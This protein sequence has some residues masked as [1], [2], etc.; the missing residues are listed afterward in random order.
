MLSVCSNVIVTKL[1]LFA[2]KLSASAPDDMLKVF[3]IL[4]RK[5]KR[6]VGGQKQTLIV[7][8]LEIQHMPHVLFIGVLMRSVSSLFHV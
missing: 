6:E 2:Q 8:A 4:I 1:S 3:D 5:R 7:L